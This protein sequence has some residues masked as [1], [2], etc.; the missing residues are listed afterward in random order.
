MYPAGLLASLGGCWGVGFCCCWFWPLTTTDSQLLSADAYIVE[1]QALSVQEHNQ[2]D[3]YLIK[4]RWRNF[5]QEKHLHIDKLVQQKLT[6][7]YWCN[8]MSVEFRT[9]MLTV[10]SCCRIYPF[11]YTRWETCFC[12]RSFSSINSL[13]MAVSFLLT[14][15]R[16]DASFLCFSRHLCR[17]PFSKKSS[18]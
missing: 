12:N 8:I 9:E 14:V 7:K 11:S 16:R 6:W 10:C 5:R 4:R 17:K 1:S 18:N 3:I 15:W 2:E 13:F